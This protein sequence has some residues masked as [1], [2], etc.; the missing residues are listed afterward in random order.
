MRNSS[1][2]VRRIALALTLGVLVIGTGAG[3]VASPR[4]RRQQRMRACARLPA[5]KTGPQFYSGVTVDV[6]ES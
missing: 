2:T 1:R 5:T 3:A 6:S 4:R